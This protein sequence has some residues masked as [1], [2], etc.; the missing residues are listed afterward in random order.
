MRTVVVGAS[1]GLGRCIGLALAQRGDQVAL[2]ARRQDRL[3]SAVAETGGSAVA[4]ACDVTDE[5]ACRTAIEQ[6][7]GKLGGIDAVVYAPGIG[8][9]R[10]IA[11]LDAA[12]WRHVFDTNVIGASTVT[13]AALPHLRESQ[14][15]AIYLTTVNGSVT[16]P[17]PGLASYAVSKAALEKLIDAWRGEHPDVG[18]TKIVVGECI[19]GEGDSSSEFANGWDREL[20]GRFMPGW[21]AKGQMSGGL[22]D[23]SAVVDAVTTAMNSGAR[24]P[25]LVVV[26][27]LPA[28]S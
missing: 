11:E 25:S 9:L 17:W 10:P 20:A 21:I 7:A 24:I 18:F 23:G 13:A 28:A 4:I 27:R 14:G 16:S 8:P 26:P 2:L 22:M 12:T 1:S 5:Q 6:A 19:G 15:V 3:E